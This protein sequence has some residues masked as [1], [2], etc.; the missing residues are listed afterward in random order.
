MDFLRTHL[1]A[2]GNLKLMCYSGRGGEVK[3]ADGTWYVISRDEAKRRFS[4]GQANV[5][6]CTDA[7]AEGLNFQFCGAMINYD[8]P[9]NPMRVE[10]R[11]G[12]IDRLGQLNPIIRIVNLH[13]ADTVETDVYRALRARIGLFE[14]VVGRLQPILS[15]LPKKISETILTNR[16]RGQVVTEIETAVHETGSG[17]DLDSA[18]ES[19]FEPVSRDKARYDFDDLDRVV[20]SEVVRPP[21]IALDRLR[22]REYAYSAPG[23]DKKIRITTDPDYF[24]EHAESMELWSPGNPLFPS[25]TEIADRQELKGDCSI[26]QILDGAN[27]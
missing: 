18:T 26:D 19:P 4:E 8:M 3:N 7:A 22:Y 20:S 12:R 25:P 5:L 17:L 27:P 1:S 9:W 16:D 23:M 15:Q 24:Q 14:S 13:Y 11:I 21:G 2:D 10:Q 6:L